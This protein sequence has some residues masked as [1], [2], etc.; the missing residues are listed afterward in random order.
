MWKEKAWKVGLRSGVALLLASLGTAGCDS[1]GNPW[2]MSLKPFYTEVDLETDRRLAGTWRD[3]EGEVTF[4]FDCT[5]E[6]AQQ[7]SCQLAVKEKEGSGEAYGEFT[8][9][10]FALGGFRFLDLYPNGSVDAS[11]FH[12]AHFVRAHTIARLELRENALE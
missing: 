12:R 11:E 10:L 9:H 1:E 2:A 4:S 5:I 7:A 3:S 6:E 8:A